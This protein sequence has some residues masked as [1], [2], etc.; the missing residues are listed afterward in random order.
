MRDISPAILE[1]YNCPD[2]LEKAQLAQKIY[3]D[4]CN[5]AY[6]YAAGKRAVVYE[7]A[8]AWGE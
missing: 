4:L 1:A 3:T 8:G 5:Q 6:S 2:P 7:F